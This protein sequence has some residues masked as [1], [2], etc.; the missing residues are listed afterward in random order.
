MGSR[1]RKLCEFPA[2]CYTGDTDFLYADGGTFLSDRKKNHD[3]YRNRAD[4]S[5]W[6]QYLPDAGLFTD[7]LCMGFY[8]RYLY[9]YAIV[10]AILATLPLFSV[11]KGNTILLKDLKPNV[12]VSAVTTEV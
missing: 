5:W 3:L 2:G 9:L 12:A 11:K 8:F 1:W 6:T 7:D 4:V 10:C